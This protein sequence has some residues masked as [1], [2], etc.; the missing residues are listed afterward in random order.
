MIRTIEKRSGKDWTMTLDETLNDL[1]VR[2]F[3]DLLEIEGKS[4]ITEEFKDISTN[5]MHIIEAIGIEEPKRMSEVAKLMSVTMGT[6]TKAMDALTDKEYVIRERSTKDKRVI[7]VRLTDKGKKAYYH[8]ESFHRQMIE[9]IKGELSEQ[10]STVLIYA[11]AKL[12]DYFQFNYY[13][14]DE[15]SEYV[16]WKKIEE[17]KPRS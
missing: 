7:R 14:A 9:N 2:L 15:E 17:N 3:K 4:L 1:L 10:E 11:L 6:L 13:D 12:V 16:D 5:D 8:H